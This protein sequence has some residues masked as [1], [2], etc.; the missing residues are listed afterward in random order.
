MCGMASH[1]EQPRARAGSAQLGA[2]PAA[3]ASRRR[4]VEAFVE[5][6]LRAILRVD[7][8]IVRSCA[9]SAACACAALVE[10]REAMC[11]ARK[12]YGNMNKAHL[13]CY[14][15]FQCTQ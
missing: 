4:R 7:D 6:E 8:G 1:S 11:G 10:H 15:S 3:A 9:P 2:P 13:L 14:G 12:L 5:R